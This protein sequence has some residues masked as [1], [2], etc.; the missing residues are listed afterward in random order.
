MTLLERLRERLRSPRWLPIALQ[1]PQNLVRV[2]LVTK[3]RRFDVT[4]KTVVAALDPLTIA[5]AWTKELG[6]ALETAAPLL[7]FVD[8]ASDFTLGRLSLQRSEILSL[9]GT[10][11]ILFHAPAGTDYC[12]S[13]PQR[14]HG[15][16]TRAARALRASGPSGGLQMT[17]AAIERLLIFYICPRPVV[18][19]SVCEGGEGNLFPMDLLGHSA[20]DVSRWPCGTPAHPS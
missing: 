1:Q 3:G 14:T 12:Q 11:T 6:A 8:E 5:L 2:M 16:I 4:Q 18:L 17:S 20:N 13:W 19:V 15:Q 10:E 9:A 7:E